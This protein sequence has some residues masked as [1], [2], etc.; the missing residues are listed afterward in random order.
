MAEE[1]KTIIVP[2]NQNNNG[3]AG[4]P[5]SIPLTGLGLG[6]NYPYPP[7]AY[8]MGNNGMFGGSGFGAGILGGLLGGLIWGGIGGNGFGGW[9]NNGWG[10]GA[11]FLGN[12]MN[13]DNNTDLIMQAIN[14]TDSDVRLLATTLN[15][16]V[17]AVKEGICAI[18]SGVESVGAQVGLTGQQVLNSI[19][20]GDAALSR[21]LC[22]CCCENRLLTTEQ[23]Y[24]AQIRTI[25][26][27]NQLGSQADRNTASVVGAINALHTDMT[28]EFC[29]IKEREMQAEINNKSELI[30]QLRGQI[31][32]ANQTAQITGYVQSLIAPL[33]RDVDKIRENQPNTVP[34]QWP[35]LTAVNTTPY[36][37]GGFYGQNP[38]WGWGNGFFGGF[39]N[40][41]GGNIVF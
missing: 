12:Q 31:D 1:S 13:N 29:N 23:G 11:A 16:D 26:Q 37:S 36:V 8:G 41:F 6:N 7:Y 32:N 27:T 24:Q 14:G 28:R 4:L 17:N 15:A 30:T 20:S 5:V 38:G 3:W 34:V 2:D 9:G 21:Q 25:E 35:Q 19:L 22:E 39:G 33:Q 18:R 40:G 10:N